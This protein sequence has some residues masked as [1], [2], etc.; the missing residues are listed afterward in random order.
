MSA[1]LLPLSSGAKVTL[2]REGFAISEACKQGT[3]REQ[4]PALYRIRT[5]PLADGVLAAPNGLL[6]REQGSHAQ[7]Q[8]Q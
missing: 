8:T 1:A 6:R 7:D 2:V 3:D 4:V 5:V